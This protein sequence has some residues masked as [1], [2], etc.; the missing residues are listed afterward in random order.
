MGR[1]DAHTDADKQADLELVARARKRDKAAFGLLV[2]RHERRAYAVALAMLRNPDDARDVTQE[3]FLKAWRSLD[4]FEGQAA[5]STWLHRIVANLCIDAMRKRRPTTSYDDAHVHEEDDLPEADEMMPQTAG[6][7]P[8]RA[9]ENK[10]LGQAITAALDK[11]TD[12]HRAVLIMRELEG[13]SY[14]DMAQAMGCSEGTIMSRLFHARK[15]LQVALREFAHAPAAAAV[16]HPN[17]E[18]AP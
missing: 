6:F 7:H 2:G 8:G 4:T 12:N 18:P 11:L 17:K 9:L 5:F 15:K 16:T 14:H 1:T 3:A 13:M 10:E